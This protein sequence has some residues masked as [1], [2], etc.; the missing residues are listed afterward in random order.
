M[1]R[2]NISS[3]PR[4][5]FYLFFIRIIYKTKYISFDRQPRFSGETKYNPFFGSLRIGGNGVFAY[6]TFGL[7]M[8][9]NLGML[10][11]LTSILIAL[12]YF[13]AKIGGYLF[14][15]GFTTVIISIFIVGAIN[16]FGLAI[17]GQYIQRI[18]EETRPRP[19]YI[20]QETINLEKIDK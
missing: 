2:P 10:L 13:F 6:S 3:F 7:S 16:M 1:W 4:T 8:I 18:Y 17:I 14:P 9:F 5:P 12:I 11:A 20:I 15:W 19:R